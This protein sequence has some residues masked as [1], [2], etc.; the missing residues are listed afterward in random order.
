MIKHKGKVLTFAQALTLGD[1][2]LRLVFDITLAEIGRNEVDSIAVGGDTEQPQ[3]LALCDY[4]RA[5]SRH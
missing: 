4:G 2:T 1:Q 3:R 5:Q